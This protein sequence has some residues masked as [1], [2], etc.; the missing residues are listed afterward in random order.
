MIL[1]VAATTTMESSRLGKDDMKIYKLTQPMDPEKKFERLIFPTKC[2]V[3]PKSL[4]RLAIGQVV[5][6]TRK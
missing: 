5:V 4:S 1:Q 3:I 6:S 2:H